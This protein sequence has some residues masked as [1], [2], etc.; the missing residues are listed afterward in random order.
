MV[1]TSPRELVEIPRTYIRFSLSFPEEDLCPV[2]EFSWWSLD[3][4]TVDR[5]MM[6]KAEEG[7]WLILDHAD[8]FKFQS[9]LVATGAIVIGRDDGL[10]S[11][12]HIATIQIRSKASWRT[13]T[14]RADCLGT[15]S[16]YPSGRVCGSVLNIGS[17]MMN[18]ERGYRSQY[19][20]SRGSPV[21]E[22]EL[23]L[24]FPGVA[25]CGSLLR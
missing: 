7:D 4:N 1:V 3:R 20:C 11:T 12:S 13:T 6:C 16:T 14:G 2:H 10:S 25:P 5:Q 23:H 22:L 17:S 9:R 24:S 15:C 19:S 21:L 18:I 8:R